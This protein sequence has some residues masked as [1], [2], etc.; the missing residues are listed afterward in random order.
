MDGR[1]R[2]ARSSSTTSSWRAT[3]CASCSDSSAAIE[4]V[5]QAGNGIEA[6]RV[7][8]GAAAG[9]GDARRADARAH[10]LRGGAPAACA[11]GIDA[12]FVF[13]TAFDQHAIEAFEVNAVDY[14]LKPVEAGAA[15]D[16]GRAGRGGG[17]SRT[18]RPRRRRRRRR[19]G[20]AA[21]AAGGPPGPPRAAGDQGR[22][23]GSCWSRRTR[24]SMPRSRTT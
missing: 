19:A 18:G 5:G 7:D 1:A 9:P 11:A 16:R 17:S 24:S 23:T 14:L 4:V 21:A 6:L 22:R 2:C 10:R 13:V 8:R 12:Q 20:T 15:G 3:S